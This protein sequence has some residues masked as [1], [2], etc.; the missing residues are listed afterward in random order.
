MDVD[1]QGEAYGPI[2]EALP[3]EIVAALAVRDPWRTDL[4]SSEAGLE[5]LGSDEEAVGGPARSAHD[6]HLISLLDAHAATSI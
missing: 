2:Y 6:E 5:L 3:D 4:A 1:E